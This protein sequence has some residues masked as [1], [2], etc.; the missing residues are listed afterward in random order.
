[1]IDIQS[2]ISPINGYKSIYSN[3]A[4]RDPEIIANEYIIGYSNMGGGVRVPERILVACL[5]VRVYLSPGG[6]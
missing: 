6:E 1:M 5:G 4:R 2:R 3:P